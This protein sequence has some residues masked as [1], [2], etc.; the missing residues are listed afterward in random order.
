MDLRVA[1]RELDRLLERDLGVLE[2]AELEADEPEVVV[3]RVDL[4]ALRDQLAV[5]L[6]RLAELLPAVV[7][8]AQQ[9]EHARVARAQQV[10]FLELP[11]GLVEALRLEELAA[12]VVVGEEEAL[13]EGPP[14]YRLGHG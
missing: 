6:L 13:V 9:V 14:G 3:E 1:L 12:L 5:D 11:L 10:G 8:E 7:D 2:P 4:G